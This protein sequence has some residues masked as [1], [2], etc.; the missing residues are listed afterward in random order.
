MTLFIMGTAKTPRDY[1]PTISADA[2][3]DK[4]MT[5]PSVLIQALPTLIGSNSGV[6]VHSF[7]SY[8]C[9]EW[10]EESHRNTLLTSTHREKSNKKMLWKIMLNMEARGNSNQQEY[11]PLQYLDARLVLIM[12]WRCG[13]AKVAQLYILLCLSFVLPPLFFSSFTSTPSHRLCSPSLYSQWRGRNH[14]LSSEHE[15][16]KQKNNKYNRSLH[17]SRSICVFLLTRSHFTRYGI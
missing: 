8:L 14:T 10:P 16:K 1:W 6:L 15:R 11:F 3:F 5:L 12:L 9:L 2:H 7:S 4:G 17:M 13:I